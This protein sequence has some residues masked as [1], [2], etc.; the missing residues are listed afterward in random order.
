MWRGPTWWKSQR[1]SMRAP[2][3][4]ATFIL[5][6]VKM[7]KPKKEKT[8]TGGSSFNFLKN[9]K[10]SRDAARSHLFE[11][12]AEIMRAPIELGRVKMRKLKTLT[13]GS[14]FNFLGQKLKNVDKC[15]GEVAPGAWASGKVW[16]HFYPLLSDQ[17]SKGACETLILPCPSV[18]NKI[19][20]QSI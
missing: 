4:P 14:P 16:G 18:T 10:F 9:W 8:L 2:I 19:V 3:K 5:G 1:K 12:P 17:I 13:G 15:G 6:R 20:C 7:R 11:K